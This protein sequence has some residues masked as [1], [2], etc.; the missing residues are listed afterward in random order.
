MITFESLLVNPRGFLGFKTQNMKY[1]TLDGYVLTGETY[2]ELVD[3]MRQ[4]SK[5][6]SDTRIGFMVQVSKRCYEYNESNVRTDT[7][8]N[9]ILD[10]VVSGFLNKTIA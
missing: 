10:L 6:E 1:T 8:E 9:F 3:K 5:T 7:D 4:D 2:G